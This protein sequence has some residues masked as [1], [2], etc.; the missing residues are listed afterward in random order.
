LIL[1]N[2]IDSFLLLLILFEITAALGLLLLLLLVRLFT[3]QRLAAGQLIVDVLIGGSEG[4]WL[5]HW[6]VNGIVV[7]NNI[8]WR[9]DFL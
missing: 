7:I 1:I 2:I 9:G 5:R 3:V 8:K 4:L 6:P